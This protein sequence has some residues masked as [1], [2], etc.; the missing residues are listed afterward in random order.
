MIIKNV[1]FLL[2]VLFA[3]ASCQSEKDRQE[4]VER[5]EQQRIELEERLKAKQEEEAFRLEEE[6][7]EA[8]E[9]LKEEREKQ[10][11]YEKYIDKSLATGS[12]PYAHCFG[13]NSSCSDR[14]C[15]QIRVKT[16]SN[17][18]VLV[19]V[20]RGEQVVRHA[21][22]KKGDSYTFEV[23]N[24]V[25]QPFF[26]YGKG[27]NAE[28]V[29]K[30]TDCGILKG[31]F[32]ASESFGKDDPQTLSNNVLEYELILQERGNFSTIPSNANEAL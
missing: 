1:F 8:E 5:E 9:R 3:F 21:F 2:V 6:R 16:P 30:E 18:D 7:L 12:V 32:I 4:I 11:L 27:W 28:K 25:Y 24:G 20:K 26:Y 13:R 14:G 19:T 22:I 29:M 15:S 10:A 17:S 31:G 23:P